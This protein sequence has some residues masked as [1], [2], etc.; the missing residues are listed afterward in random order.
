MSSNTEINTNNLKGMTLEIARYY[1][2]LSQSIKSQLEAILPY[3]KD[4]SKVY[5]CYKRL[6]NATKG[7][8]SRKILLYCSIL[9]EVSCRELFKEKW[10]GLVFCYNNRGEEIKL[11]KPIARQWRACITEGRM[12]DGTV[13][14]VKFY[15]S[16]K[17][18]TSY[19][20][21]IYKKLK[22]KGCPDL[23]F[24]ISGYKFMELPVLV[25]EKLSPLSS[26]DNEF[27]V[28]SDVLR[29]LQVLNT[30]ACHSDL[31]PGN[32]MAKRSKGK[33]KYT[34]IDLGGCATERLSYG[35][36]RFVW[37]PIAASQP[38]HVRGQITSAYYDLL[39]LTCVG[40]AIQ[41]W[42][43]EPKGTKKRTSLKTGYT[44]KLLRYYERVKECNPKHVKPSDYEDLIKILQGPE[45]T[46]YTSESEIESLI[47]SETETES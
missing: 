6:Y 13:C 38:P 32:V 34:M 28:M 23:P 31:K 21:N 40:K 15:L 7:K 29:Q 26:K 35:F 46:L 9:E 25:L 1:N 44:G 41:V 24:F 20:I 30:F 47:D 22:E 33:T 11:I 16:E 4:D 5:S 10:F 8:L 27:D 17:R 39:E 2:D 3:F 37:T 36:K 18:S 14:V 45:D 42:R 19:E 12:S 43:T